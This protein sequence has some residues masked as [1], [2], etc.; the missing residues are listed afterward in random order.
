MRPEAGWCVVDNRDPADMETCRDT[1][2][3]RLC[4]RPRRATELGPHHRHR[5]PACGGDVWRHL[6]GAGADGL[7]ARHHT[8]LLGCRHGVVPAG[9]RQPAAELSGLELLGDRTGDGCHGL[10]RNRQRAGR[11]GR[12]RPRVDRHRRHRAPG[13]N[14]LDRRGVAASGHGGDRRVD[15]FQPG[16]GCKVEFREGPA[17][18]ARDARAPS[19]DARVLPRHHRPAGDLP[20]RCHGLCAGADSRRGRH[21][22][23]NGGVVGGAARVPDPDVH[24]GSAADVP[25]RRNRAGR[26]EHR[27]CQVG[28][29][30]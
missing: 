27:A 23:D 30:R 6:P 28:S 15:R 2:G 22:G 4:R 19:R 26:R 17:G 8:A 29:A 3:R 24:G 7:S 16:T 5:R 21:V 9:H 14:P 18:R 12:G 1:V 25:A 11:S 10:A 13:R 20:G